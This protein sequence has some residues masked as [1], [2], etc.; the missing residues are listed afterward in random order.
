MRDSRLIQGLAALVTLGAAATGWLFLGNGFGPSFDSA[1]HRAAGA[2]LAREAA[3][4]L[5]PGGHLTVLARDTSVFGNP[6]ADTLLSAFQDTLRISH[7]P[8]ATVRLF[9]VDP[10]R[11]VEVPPGDFAEILRKSPP[12]DVVVSFLG[13][14]WLDENQRGRLGSKH[15]TVVAFCPGHGAD[16]QGLPD[17]FRA[18]LVE[19]AIISRATTRQDHAGGGPAAAFDHAFQ[20]VT[21]ANV[22][23]AVALS[24]V[25]GGKP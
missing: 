25:G 19:S 8:A 3:R 2:A 23:A 22:E 17:L 7:Q 24:P 6:A 13:P 9:K 16:I 1:P 21:A 14:P 10:L 5:K 15:P 20:V 18:G 11:R 12:E 4:A